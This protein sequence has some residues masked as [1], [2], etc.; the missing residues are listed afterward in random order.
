MKC[1]LQI[2]ASAGALAKLLAFL[3]S[4]GIESS[5]ATIADYQI[6]D[7]LDNV[8][9]VVETPVVPP[10]PAGDAV[11]TAPVVQ[12]PVTPAQPVAPL[13]PPAVT[14]DPNAELDA[15]GIPWD[16]RIPVSYT[17]LTLP[18]KA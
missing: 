4:E 8:A 2:T 15:D 10:M 17:H 14:I 7:A 12:P 11:A 3:S 9:P 13:A 16:E 5:T 1:T 18:T 6:N